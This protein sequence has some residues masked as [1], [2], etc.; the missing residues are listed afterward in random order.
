MGTVSLRNRGLER[1]CD[2]SSSVAFRRRSTLS[3]RASAVTL[4]SGPRA[5]QVLLSMRETRKLIAEHTRMLS[6][7][8]RK[9]QH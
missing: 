8:S 7:Q 5:V 1:G 3:R 9:Y 6:D 2:R 4:S